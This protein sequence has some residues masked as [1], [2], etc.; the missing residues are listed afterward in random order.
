MVLVSGPSLGVSS[1]AID[2]TS[3]YWTQASTATNAPTIM[4]TGT[5]S[6]CPITGCTGAPTTLATG[7]AYPQGIWLGGPNLYWLDYNAATLMQ[8]TVDCNDDATTF[9]KWPSIGPGGFAASATEAFI[10][11]G[12][13]VEQCPTSGCGTP[14]TF[15]SGQNPRDIALSGAGVTWIDLGTLTGGKAVVFVDGGVMNCPLDGCDGGPTVLASA[16]SYPNSLVVNGPTAYW[17]QSNSVLACSV[18]GCG[19]MPTTIVSLPASN[20]IVEAIAVD[21]TDVYFGS[22]GDQTGTPWEI[23]RCALSGCANGA[24]LLSSTPS[25]QGGPLGEIAV[26]ATRIYFASGDTF[27]IL[28]LAK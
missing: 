28:A 4:P 20:A 24:T 5:V 22:T 26:D 13:A 2:A 14:T 17:A 11:Y 9:H 3:V 16:L 7:Q 27:Q 1:F 21:A 15:A 12:G 18:A 23:W 6:K 8:C 10:S 25:G 19:G